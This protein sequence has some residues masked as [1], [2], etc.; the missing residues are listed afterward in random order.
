MSVLASVI[1]G[2][3]ESVAAPRRTPLAFAACILDFV[4]PTASAFA[5]VSEFAID[6]GRAFGSFL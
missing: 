3:T 1:Q 6:V 5:P 2:L 4:G